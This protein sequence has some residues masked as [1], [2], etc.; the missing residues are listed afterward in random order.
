MSAERLRAAATLL[1][2]RAEGATEGNRRVTHDPLGTHVET[3]LDAMGRVVFGS[4]HD[5]GPERVEGDA[6]YIA[7]MAPPVALALAD[8]LDAMAVFVDSGN[9]VPGMRGR[10]LTE[11]L[12]VADAIL[13][14]HP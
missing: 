11:A 7:L 6:A 13:G 3:D 1:R 9:D 5:R 10:G 8:W 12:A 14:T 4:S 2:E